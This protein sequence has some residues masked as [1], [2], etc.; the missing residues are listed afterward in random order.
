MVGLTRCQTDVRGGDGASG[1]M[2]AIFPILR[3]FW[4][5][6]HSTGTLPNSP[7]MLDQQGQAPGE[8]FIRVGTDVQGVISKTGEGAGHSA[9]KRTVSIR[10]GK[11]VIP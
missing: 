3:A 1:P 5:V 2:R 7:T 8:S 4:K 11:F 9:G 6:E 10:F